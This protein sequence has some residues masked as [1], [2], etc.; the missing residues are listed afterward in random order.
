MWSV[1]A[2]CEPAHSAGHRRGHTGLRTLLESVQ[3]LLQ[4]LC[5]RCPATQSTPLDDT[6]STQTPCLQP[7]NAQSYAY[8]GEGDPGAACAGG[9]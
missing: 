8:V 3:S 9:A 7:I 5:I 4:D 6:T 2:G 1:W